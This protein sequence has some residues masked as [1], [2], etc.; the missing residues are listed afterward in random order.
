MPTTLEK[1]KKVPIDQLFCYQA[2]LPLDCDE[3]ELFLVETD[4]ENEFCKDYLYETNP[5]QF[6]PIRCKWPFQVFRLNSL[7]DLQSLV[8]VL[9]THPRARVKSLNTLGIILQEPNG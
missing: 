8:Q 9:E 2:E 1:P 4:G 3:K 6:A 7:A 5:V